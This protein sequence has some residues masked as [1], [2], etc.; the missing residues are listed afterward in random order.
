MPL[1][2]SGRSDKLQF[3]V[4]SP[5]ALLA[6]NDDKLKFVGPRGALFRIRQQYPRSPHSTGRYYLRGEPVMTCG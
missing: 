1:A 3:V 2:N 4:G 6:D 5:Q